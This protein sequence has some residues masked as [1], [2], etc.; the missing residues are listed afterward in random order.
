MRSIARRARLGLVIAAASGGI[1]SC[2]PEEPPDMSG[3]KGY[4]IEYVRLLNS[5][6][7][8]DLRQHLGNEAQPQDARDRI[9]AS[10][11][12]EWKFE[13]A[14]WVELTTGAA[15]LTIT[16]SHGGEHDVWRN[17]VAWNGHQWVMG[18]MSLK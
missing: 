13:D 2:A 9:A 15:R 3:L 1:A 5:R 6:N 11:T 16:A 12:T 14:S 4:A 8:S 7:E 10:G 17:N 18:P